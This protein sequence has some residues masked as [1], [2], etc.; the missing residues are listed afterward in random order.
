MTRVWRVARGIAAALRRR[1]NPNERINMSRYAFFHALLVAP[2]FVAA[3]DE[4]TDTPRTLPTAEVEQPA[5]VVD[6]NSRLAQVTSRAFGGGYVMFRFD[7]TVDGIDFKKTRLMTVRPDASGK[8]QV[9]EAA[10]DMYLDET[11]TTLAIELAD[12]PKAGELYR[13]V[14]EIDGDY[15]DLGEVV[16]R[17]AT[18][19]T[20]LRDGLLLP[21]PV[22]GVAET[23]SVLALQLASTTP[24]DGATNVE[25]KLLR[26]TVAF[27]S[28]SQV[29]CTNPITGRDAFRLYSVDPALPAWR[30]QE[31]YP[32]MD[33]GGI[34]G[35][36]FVCD[37]ARNQV[38]MELPYDVGYLLGGSIFKV[39]TR[40]RAT[41]G[42][43]LSVTTTF[44]T[45]NPGLEV[46]L[47]KATNEIYQC[48]TKYPFSSS[49]RCDMY[50]LSQVKTRVGPN[51]AWQVNKKY[52]ESGDW[53]NWPENNSKVF[54][55]PN[56]RVLYQDATAV[57]DPVAVE[58]HAYDADTGTGASKALNFVGGLGKVVS[59]FWPPAGAIG[60]GLTQVAAALPAD[61]D[62]FYGGGTYFLPASTRW[63]T[64]TQTHTFRLPPRAAGDQ[65]VV[66]LMAFEYPPSWYPAPRID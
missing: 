55:P 64:V 24:A 56:H 16:I 52:P 15:V 45:V 10:G 62:D 61:D 40:A 2:L 30:Q 31:M 28:A 54:Y 25:R 6:S 22:V 59:P 63:G 29:N 8:L 12:Q 44:R 4:P 51:E 48:D 1:S 60:E 11:N 66:E 38:S 26:V 7:R 19:D 35:P 39:D 36:T 42:T 13:A 17:A 49:Y 23:P 41:D 47:T 20:P 57:G 58:I 34:P 3:C 46:I 37:A 21:P 65:V 32:G 5:A 43:T 27:T 9:V 53:A 14:T 18:K 33:T 50:L